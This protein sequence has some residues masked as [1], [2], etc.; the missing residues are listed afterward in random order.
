MNVNGEQTEPF[1]AR[2]GLRQG[3]P[4]SPYLFVICM[5][6]SNRCLKGLHNN[7]SFPFHPRCKRIGLVHVC[8][9]DDLHMFARGDTMS[10]QQLMSILDTFAAASG[11]KAN[12]L[13][14]CIYFGGVAEG[15][16]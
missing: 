14:S 2:K 8:F 16:K 15:T 12:Q 5:E 7:K 11:L 6:Y 9:A 4:I 3:D 13:K 10:V 1:E